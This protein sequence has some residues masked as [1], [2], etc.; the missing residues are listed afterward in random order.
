MCVTSQSSS[1]VGKQGWRAGDC[2]LG[3]Q[4]V[5]RSRM[6]SASLQQL[7]LMGEEEQ[8]HQ[9]ERF[10]SLSLLSLALSLQRP[11]PT[12]PKSV[13]AGKGI[14]LDV[15]TESSSQANKSGFEL[16]GKRL[17]ASGMMY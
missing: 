11:L 9:E 13:P 2:P 12:K 17:F 10:L 4:P 3:A 5:L 16:R 15:A 14:L 1:T 8:P 6:S 7:C